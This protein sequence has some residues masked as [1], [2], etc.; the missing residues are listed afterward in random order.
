MVKRVKRFLVFM[1]FSFFYS[2][3]TNKSAEADTSAT[4]C[5]V[6]KTSGGKVK[7]N[8]VATSDMAQ[9]V[10]ESICSG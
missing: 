4:V 3:L 6:P 10:A 9:D 1:L 7:Y 8:G 5:L 2:L